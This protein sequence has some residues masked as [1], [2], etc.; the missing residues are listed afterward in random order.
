[1]SSVKGS[2]QRLGRALA[3]VSFVIAREGSR[4]TANRGGGGG[5]GGRLAEDAEAAH[6]ADAVWWM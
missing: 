5:G 1:V 2:T 4:Q 3:L 6:N